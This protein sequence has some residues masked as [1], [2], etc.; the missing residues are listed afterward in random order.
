MISL[1]IQKF[2]NQEING[3]E[4][5]LHFIFFLSLQPILYCLSP[6]YIVWL[7]VLKKPIL[8]SWYIKNILDCAGFGLCTI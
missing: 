6:G 7:S 2:E 8:L 5:L 1:S 3:H 4:F